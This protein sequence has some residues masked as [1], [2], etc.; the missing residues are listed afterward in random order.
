MN[1][2]YF[3]KWADNKKRNSLQTDKTMTFLASMAPTPFIPLRGEGE[4]EREN[5]YV[6]A[7]QR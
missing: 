4:R 5:A 2:N 7:N 1:M 6:P 3:P